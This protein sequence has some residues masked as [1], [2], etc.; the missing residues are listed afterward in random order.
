MRIV[1]WNVNGLRSVLAKGFRPWLSRSRAAIVGVQEVRARE[2]QL[3]EPLGPLRRWHRHLV[4]A[5]RPGYSGVALFSRR[6]PDE[7]VTS[8]GDRA[9]DAEGRF[10]LARFGRL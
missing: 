8:L 10:Q 4:E 6:A 3:G 1:S 9:F 7:V 2:A 5:E